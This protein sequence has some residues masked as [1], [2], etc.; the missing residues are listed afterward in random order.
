[1]ESQIWKESSKISMSRNIVRLI[2]SSVWHQFSQLI[3]LWYHLTRFLAELDTS[4]SQ[5]TGKWPWLGAPVKSSIEL[6]AMVLLKE[7]RRFG[8]VMQR[9]IK[10][11]PLMQ[12]KVGVFGLATVRCSADSMYSWKRWP[13]CFR[14]VSFHASWRQLKSPMD[15]RLFIVC[16]LQKATQVVSNFTSRSSEVWS[17]GGM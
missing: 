11:E 14:V 8:Q 7:C 12:L 6:S 2:S 3:V 4:H 10:L 9:S 16:S 1:M 13:F 15:F 5:V 17:S